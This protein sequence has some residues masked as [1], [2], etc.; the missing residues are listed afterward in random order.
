M[1][2]LNEEFFKYKLSELSLE[3]KDVRVSY[4][5]NN[6]ANNMPFDLF[7]GCHFFLPFSD[8]PAPPG[9]QSTVITVA[10]GCF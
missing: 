10:V 1:I 3:D 6:P 5:I 2:S 9:F 8:S 7:V 4:V